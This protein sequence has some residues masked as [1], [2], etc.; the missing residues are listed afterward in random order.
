[1]LMHF[2]LLFKL[3]ELCKIVKHFIETQVRWSH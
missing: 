1:M 2:K 3:L